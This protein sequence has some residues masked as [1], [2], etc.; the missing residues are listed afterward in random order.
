MKASARPPQPAFRIGPYRLVRSIGEG[1][2]LALGTGSGALATAREF[3]V[4]SG[5]QG[6]LI[7]DFNGELRP[8]I[9]TANTVG[10]SFRVRLPTGG[11]SV[12]AGVEQLWP[13]RPGE[14]GAGDWNGNGLSAARYRRRRL[15]LRWA[16]GLGGGQAARDVVQRA[17]ELQSVTR[18]Q[19]SRAKRGEEM[20]AVARQVLVI[21][22]L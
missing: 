18:P 17:S 20:H 2:T 14:L 11:G 12:V 8:D 13:A 15:Q 9:A 21:L 6:V 7:A 10:N 19:D 1:V 3:A 16:V 22:S 4:G 5:P